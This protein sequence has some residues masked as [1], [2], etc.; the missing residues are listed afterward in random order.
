MFPYSGMF[1][2]ENTFAGYSTVIILCIK[3]SKH[4]AWHFEIKIIFN[5][6]FVSMGLARCLS[7]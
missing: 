7:G 4:L 3:T 5:K 1:E 6:K 2:A